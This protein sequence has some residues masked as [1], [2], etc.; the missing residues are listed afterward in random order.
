MTLFYFDPW[1]SWCMTLVTFLVWNSFRL[2][3]LRKRRRRALRR[4]RMLLFSLV[5][6]YWHLFW[7]FL[8][9]CD[10][11]LNAFD[12]LFFFFLHIQRDLLAK[13]HLADFCATAEA[14]TS[15]YLK[16]QCDFQL[17]VRHSLNSPEHLWV[18]CG[19]GTE[20]L[21]ISNVSLFLFSKDFFL[22]FITSQWQLLSL[23]Q[24]R[25]IVPYK[26]NF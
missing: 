8:C 24:N 21:Y 7:S 5:K 19:V 23:M 3:D 9:I 2:A 20:F 18:Q 14:L 25:S 6:H 26:S 15:V 11:T 16:V 17:Q 1:R 4:L 13:W 12:V 10:E 22:F